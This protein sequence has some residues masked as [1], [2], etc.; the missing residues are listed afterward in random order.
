MRHTRARHRSDGR[1]VLIELERDR[2]PREVVAQALDHG[3]LVRT[4][5]DDDIAAIF[6]ALQKRFNAP[7]AS[8][9]RDEAFKQRFRVP[10]CG[11]TW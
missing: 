10:P 1:I 6:D 11:A 4:L 2:T 5:K 8:R 7:Q 9:S 3:S